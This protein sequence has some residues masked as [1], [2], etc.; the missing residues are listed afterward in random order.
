MFLSLWT[1]EPE[2]GSGFYW[3]LLLNGYVIGYR[4]HCTA[5]SQLFS[6]TWKM[7][8]H[9]NWCILQS[10]WNDVKHDQSTPLSGTIISSKSLRYL[11][12]ATID[13]VHFKQLIQVV[14]TLDMILFSLFT[15]SWFKCQPI[16][17]LKKLVWMQ[18]PLDVLANICQFSGF[19]IA[20][21]LWWINGKL[22]SRYLTKTL[23]K[24]KML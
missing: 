13:Y 18:W 5:L 2:R 9:R 14:P 22:H 1:R 7:V 6:S 20:A 11:S 4:K 12:V 23:A 3:K 19:V 17:D 24:L 16:W 15:W 10:T 8:F 21:G